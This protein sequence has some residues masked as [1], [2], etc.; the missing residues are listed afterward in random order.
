[1]PTPQPAPLKNKKETFRG[2]LVYK[3]AIPAGFEDA[4]RLNDVLNSMAVQQVSS[5]NPY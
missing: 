3:Q 4:A 5:Q 1:M 2:R